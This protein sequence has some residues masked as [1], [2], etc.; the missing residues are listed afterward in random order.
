MNRSAFDASTH[1]CL[2]SKRIISLSCFKKILWVSEVEK[3]PQIRLFHHLFSPLR[4][5]QM[6]IETKNLGRAHVCRD[7]RWLTNRATTPFALLD[8]NGL[9]DVYKY[10][11]Q[12]MASHRKFFRDSQSPSSTSPKPSF[13]RSH[14]DIV[15]VNGYHTVKNTIDWHFLH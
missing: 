10:K 11:F 12:T 9:R 1:A 7:K 2:G 4:W 13:L 5:V 6:D 14:L 3:L 15:W 8:S